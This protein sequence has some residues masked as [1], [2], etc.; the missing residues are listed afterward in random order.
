MII[1]AILTA[2]VSACLGWGRMP[3]GPL[4]LLSV[5]LG[6]VLGLLGRHE[7]GGALSIDALAQRSSLGGVNA[8]L[9]FWGSLALL[10]LCV[11]SASA[12]PGLALVLLMGVL[13]VRG[14]RVPL[15]DYLSLLALPAAFL[16]ISALAL[17]WSWGDS[18]AGVLNIPLF[19]GWLSVSPAAQ[20]RTALVICKALGAVSC[21]YLLSLSTPMAEIIA[22]L[23]RAHVPALAV[24]LMYLIYRYIF[25]LLDMHRTMHDAAQSRL[26]Y[27]GFRLSVR[28]TGSSYAN[29]LARSIKRAGACFDAMESRCYDGEIRFLE[30]EKPV[31]P[32]HAAAAAGL[33]ILTFGLSLLTF[34][35]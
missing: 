7:H 15:H 10:L 14:G 1:T 11:L 21:L 22:V 19:G 13:T 24:E 26:G 31:L 34:Q 27:D 9:K 33:L 29:L 35:I 30:R 2:L 23:R 8:V 25:I 5:G 6:L 3:P 17:L 4:G 18:P 32:V 16:L 12:L 20:A 28:T